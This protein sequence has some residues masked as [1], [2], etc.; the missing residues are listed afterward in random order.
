MYASL[1]VQEIPREFQL[2]MDRSMDLSMS[3]NMNCKR[4][5]IP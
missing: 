2:N 4:L 5:D 1:D 3:S